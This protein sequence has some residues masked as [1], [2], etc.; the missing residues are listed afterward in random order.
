MYRAV[1]KTASAVTGTLTTNTQRQ[2]SASV[3][4]P[5]RSG[6]NALPIPATPMISPPASPCR[7]LGSA[8]NV[9]PRTAGHMTAPPTPIA[10][11]A[12]SRTPME[13]AAAATAENTAKIA[14]PAKNSRR[15]PNRSARRPPV[16]IITPKTSA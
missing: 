1:T 11:R 16:T 14:A 13:G 7:S 8:A 4:K 6:P 5:P 12:A 15:R 10:A 3:R 9:I 2:L